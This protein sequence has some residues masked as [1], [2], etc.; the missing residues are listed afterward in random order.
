MVNIEHLCERKCQQATVV[1]DKCPLEVA[2]TA[3]SFLHT[4]RKCLQ[5]GGVKAIYA[6]RDIP[7]TVYTEVVEARD[8]IAAVNTYI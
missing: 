7:A 8:G 6:S 4:G 3:H 5:T 1:N 2:H